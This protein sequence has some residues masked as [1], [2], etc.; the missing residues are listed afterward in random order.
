[1][2]SPE[3]HISKSIGTR[4][5]LRADLSKP[6]S[7]IIEQILTSSESILFIPPRYS[8]RQLFVPEIPYDGVHIGLFSSGTTGNPRCM[9]VSREKLI[10]NARMTAQ[11]LGMS[12]QHHILILASPWHIAGI[13]WALMAIEQGI[14]FEIRTPYQANVPEFVAKLAFEGYS[15]LFTTPYLFR[16]LA[17]HPNWTVDEI[18]CGGSAFTIH[19]APLFVNHSRFVTSAYGQT[20]AG[21]IISAF[22]SDA[23]RWN[24]AGC[25]GRAAKDIRIRCHGSKD[26]PGPIYIHSPSAVCEGWLDTGD[27]GYKDDCENLTIT[28]RKK[29]SIN[30]AVE[31]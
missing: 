6:E 11:L 14:Q 12:V 21:G 29:D 31:K 7:A 4:T 27:Y 17:K 20:E 5:W 30:G 19:D 3:P 15:H 23:R 22:R 28:H 18:I 16:H 8:D 24:N 9:W 26:H 25:V 10:Q 1:M 13:S 2:K